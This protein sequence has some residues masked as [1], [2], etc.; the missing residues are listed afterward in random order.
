MNL[1]QL[2]QFAFSIVS[3][4]CSGPNANPW[5]IPKQAACVEKRET[6]K[7]ERKRGV[8]VSTESQLLCN[9]LDTMW[10]P[11]VELKSQQ[12][13]RG[14]A[15]FTAAKH[16]R[17][18]KITIILGVLNVTSFRVPKGNMKTCFIHQGYN[19]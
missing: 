2:Y 5:I 19:G 14:K 15:A 6:E 1:K 13:E 17:S 7:I 9:S 8:S 3:S 10:G 18:L 11:V 16:N 4:D 12:L